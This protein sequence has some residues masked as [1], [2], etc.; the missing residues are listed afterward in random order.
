MAEHG[1]RQPRPKNA[2]DEYKLRLTA[3]KFEGSQRPPMLAFQVIGNNPRID[4]YTNKPG[5]K[6]GGIIRAAMDSPTFFML[7]ETLR[8]AIDE[9]PGWKNYIENKMPARDEAGNRAKGVEVVSKTVIGKDEKGMVY[10]SVISS[11][12][13][14]PKVKFLFK[15]SYFHDLLDGEGNRLGASD[16]SCR[17]ARGF[18]RLM[19]HLSANVL[20]SHYR[21]PQP[22]GGGNK[23]GGGNRGGGYQGQSGGGQQR[24]AN[25]DFGGGGSSDF[26]DDIPL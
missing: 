20:D 14:R 26:E 23:Y 12:P 2:L 25:D 1:Q 21:Q 15:T 11:D 9:A 6:S 7:L 24:K 4:V 16:M 3:P 10:I 18:V 19:E 22:Q 17:V 13:E 8:A 5:D